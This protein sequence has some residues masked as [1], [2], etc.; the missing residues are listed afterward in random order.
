M[1]TLKI[2]AR[3][4]S[5]AMEEVSKKLGADAYILATTTKEGGVEIEATNDPIEVKKFTDKAKKSFPSL[6]KRELGNITQ[7]PK[8]NNFDSVSRRS[9]ICL[10]YT[11]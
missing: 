9:V 7:F 1:A 10:L 2:T 3:D 8:K 5:S 6:I 11:F 4:S